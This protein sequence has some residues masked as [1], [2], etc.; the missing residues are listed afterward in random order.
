MGRAKLVSTLNIALHP[1]TADAEILAAVRGAYRLL[2]G[3]TIDDFLE[4]TQPPPPSETELATKLRTAEQK[5][6]GAVEYCNELKLQTIQLQQQLSAA[7]SF[8]GNGRVKRWC[9]F[10]GRHPVISFC[11]A[12]FVIAIMANQGHNNQ[13]VGTNQSQL[14]GVTREQHELSGVTRE[15]R[16]PTAPSDNALEHYSFVGGWNIEYSRRGKFCSMT[17]TYAN[18]T[19][20]TIG[21]NEHEYA[22]LL[23]TYHNPIADDATHAFNMQFHVDSNLPKKEDVWPIE[24]KTNLKDHY[25]LFTT[26]DPK[27]MT[28]FTDSTEITFWYQDKKVESIWI[29]NQ[30]DAWQAMT[31]CQKA[32]ST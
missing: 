15:Q 7:K 1:R 21:Y 17:R 10:V 6:Q 23:R 3:K 14:S 9:G 4:Q 30:W 5:L 13:R 22:I 29:N 31:A 8:R 28:K 32:H 11:V 18:S 2:G 16:E 26:V 20:L 27:F 12:S 24:G 19:A 25:V